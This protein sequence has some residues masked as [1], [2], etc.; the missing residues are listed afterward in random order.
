M[1]Q[2]VEGYNKQGVG[3]WGGGLCCKKN[4][5]GGVILNGMS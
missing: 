2:N 1:C 4:T 3:G 5:K